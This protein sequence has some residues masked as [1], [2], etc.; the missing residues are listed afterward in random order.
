MK[1]YELVLVLKASLTVDEKKDLLDSIIDIIGKDS[2]KQTDDIGVLKAA[3]PLDGKK[4]NTHMHLISY[5]LSV[6]PL[7]VNVFTKKFAFLK[8]LV[9]HYFYA[10]KPN[11]KFMTYGEVQ[12]SLE[13]L[14]PVKEEKVKK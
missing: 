10:M 9:R 1:P 5:Y 4:E 6:D 8:G 3:Y 13:S 14:L 7:S 2:I 11:E 12:K